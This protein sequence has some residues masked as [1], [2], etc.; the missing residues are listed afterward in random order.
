MQLNMS[1]D[2]SVYQLITKLSETFAAKT[3]QRTNKFSKVLRAKAFDTLLFHKNAE[4]L[5][6]S[7]KVYNISLLSFYIQFKD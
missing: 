4:G 1:E 2:K 3:N 6:K 5:Y 7:Y